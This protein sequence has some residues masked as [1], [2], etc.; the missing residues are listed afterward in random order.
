[1][2]GFDSGLLVQTVLFLPGHV[3]E[4]Y[5]VG[6]LVG[7]QILLIFQPF[8]EFRCGFQLDQKSCLLVGQVLEYP[9]SLI[10]LIVDPHDEIGADVRQ[11]FGR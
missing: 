4:E 10:W 6:G 2:D 1:L 7:Q 3:G 11:S 5:D 8:L 9:S